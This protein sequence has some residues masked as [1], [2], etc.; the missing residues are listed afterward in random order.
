MLL[1]VAYTFRNDAIPLDE[2]T[3]DTNVGLCVTYTPITSKVFI[4]P[5]FGST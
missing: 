4:L 2:Y 3:S 1:T 5:L